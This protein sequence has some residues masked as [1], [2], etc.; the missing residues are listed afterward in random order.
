MLVLK[1]LEIFTLPITLIVF[2]VMSVLVWTPED[3]V[4]KVE[5]RVKI[6]EYGTNKSISK[7]NK[8][9]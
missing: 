5:K 9:V 8:I 1:V 3:K 7:K 2:I 6:N 4:K